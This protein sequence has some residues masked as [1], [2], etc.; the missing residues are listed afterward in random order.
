MTQQPPAPGRFTIL[1]SCINC[2]ASRE[3]APDLVHR[4][5]EHHEFFRQPQTTAEWEAAWRAVH[6]CPV[7]AVRYEG[8]KSAPDFHPAGDVFPHQLAEA[9]W[10]LGYAAESTFGAHAYA[11]RTAAG[12]VMIDGPR[13]SGRLRAWLREQGGLAHVLLTH[14]DDVGDAEAYAR[15]SGARVWIHEADREAAPFATDVMSGETTRI[16]DGLTAIHL[17]GH[18]RGS[19]L[20]HLRS[21]VHAAAPVLFSGDTIAWDRTRRRLIALRDAC[22]YDWDVLKDSLREFAASGYEFAHCFAGHG[23]SVSADVETMRVALAAL[24]ERM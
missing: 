23:G 7:A 18:T 2:G 1:P 5:A 22:W 16:A 9:V 19:V 6:V 15:E 13:R 20:F 10:R 4:G 17:P 14:G 11:A 21:G 8:D 12:L 3:V 24:I